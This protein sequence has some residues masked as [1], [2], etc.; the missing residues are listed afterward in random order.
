MKLPSWV[1]QGQTE[2]KVLHLLRLA[3]QRNPA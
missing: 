2:L 3:A 1:E